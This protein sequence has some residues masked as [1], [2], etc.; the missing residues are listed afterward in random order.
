MLCQ[1]GLIA[2]LYTALTFAVPVLSFG[3]M[4]LRLSEALTVLPI[5]YPPAVAGLTVG[6]A[7]SNLIGFLTGANPIGLIDAAVGSGAT[8]LAGLCGAFLGRR[9]TAGQHPHLRLLLGLA[10]PVVFN[11]LIVGAELTT[12]FQ[13]PFWLNCMWVA[14]GELAVC[15]ALGYPLGLALQRNGLYRRIFHDGGAPALPKTEQTGG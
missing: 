8:L 14:A 2:A 4:Q 12:L 13:A 11:G 1:N 6:C 9:L 15:Y 7:V 3:M 10:A 5:L